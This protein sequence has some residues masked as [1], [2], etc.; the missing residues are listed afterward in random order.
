[1]SSSSYTANVGNAIQY[2]SNMIGNQPDRPTYIIY[3]VGSTNL[4]GTSY[5]KQLLSGQQLYVANYNQSASTNFQELV[6]SS[7]NV[8]SVSSSIHLLNRVVS[9]QVST[10]NPVLAL[11]NRIYSDQQSEDSITFPTS[12][13]A[14]DIIFLLDETGL[15]D[16]DFSIMK[17]FLQDFTSKFSVGPSSTQ[18]ALQTYNGRTIP[19]DGFHLF[20]STSNDV[21]KQRIQQLTLAKATENSTDADLAGAIE[22]EIFFF[23][24]EA[25]GWRDD[26]TTYTI[27]L[28]HADSFYTKDTG[29]AMQIKNLTS[30]FALG[31][32]NQ[33]FDYVRNF[34]NTGFYETVRNVSSLS[35]NSPAVN[36]LLTALPLYKTFDSDA[37]VPLTYCYYYKNTIYPTP[38]SGKDAVKADYIFLVDSALGEGYTQN[39][40]N[41]LNSFITN[42]GNF[43]STG[44]DTKMAVVTYGR[45][46]NTVWSL[47]DLQDVTSLRIQIS[48][49]QITTSSGISNLRRI[50][51]NI[52]GPTSRHL[53]TRYSTYVIQTNFDNSTFSYTP[54]VTFLS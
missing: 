1:M 29:T 20:E 45:S 50:S 21:V 13:I 10:P 22:Q 36:D 38:I 2:V 27:I 47:T 40:Q 43:T 37:T 5:S 42:V 52:D 26:V 9:M 28:S 41:F 53:N 6:Y 32:N 48:N 30:V 24:T 25:N 33:R 46:V 8:F 54:Q 34:T 3:V 49:F 15:T 44:N 39:V 16:S 35:I 14:A 4:T 23:L 18:F 11:S 31:L 7:N 19:H 17:S 51:P 12:S